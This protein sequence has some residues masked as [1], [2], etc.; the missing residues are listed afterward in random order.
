M[1]LLLMDR[2]SIPLPSFLP[3]FSQSIDR[4]EID[5]LEWMAIKVEEKKSERE[6]EEWVKE[7]EVFT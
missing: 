4:Q 2:S 1:E 6:E 5:L 3:A 7:E